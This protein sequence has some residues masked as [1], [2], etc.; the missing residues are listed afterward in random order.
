MADHPLELRPTIDRLWLEQEARKDPVSHAYALWDLERFPTT[1]RFVSAMRGDATVAY[2][3]V[4]Q[5]A[6]RPPMVHWVGAAVEELTA[7]L[8]PRPLI[9][10][11]AA[12]LRD[13]V[14][15]ARGPAETYPTL[16]QVAPVGAQP[17][18]SPLE[19]HVRRLTP[20]DASRIP[21]LSE[22][23]NE[24]VAVG[25]AGMDLE[26]EFVLGGFD[27][28]TLVGVARAVV[29]LPSV[30]LVSGVYVRPSRRGQGWGLAI[31]REVQVEA[32]ERGAP[33][34]LF[35]RE[36]NLPAITVYA[37]LGFRTVARRSWYDCGVHLAP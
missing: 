18:P 20:E 7:A 31:T 19:A 33:C 6:G 21:E 25:Y 11:G 36:D 5:P 14:E 17:P 32:Q 2:L 34:A 3:L 26:S 22:G 4:W 15:A 23:T 28:G 24:P 37:H 27:R 10:T 16:V 29:R 12:E 9:V 8:P 30:W 13:R 35:V 1:V